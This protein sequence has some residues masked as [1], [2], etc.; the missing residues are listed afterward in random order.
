MNIIAKIPPR[1]GIS[2]TGVFALRLAPCS[3][4]LTTIEYQVSGDQQYFY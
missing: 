4:L 3:L 1:D 2:P